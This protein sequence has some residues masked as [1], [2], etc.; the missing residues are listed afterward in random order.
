MAAISLFQLVVLLLSIP[1]VSTLTH[2]L[3]D[4]TSNLLHDVI[5]CGTGKEFKWKKTDSEGEDIK[6]TYSCGDEPERMKTYSC[7]KGYKAHSK[8]DQVC[9]PGP[10]PNFGIFREG[11]DPNIMDTAR[12]VYFCMKDSENTLLPC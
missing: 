2:P 7:Q 3:P 9:N 4:E 11:K 10:D 6:L 12:I 8:R 1:L 5:K